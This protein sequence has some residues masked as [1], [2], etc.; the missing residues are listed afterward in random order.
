MGARENKLRPDDRACSKSVRVYNYSSYC[1]VGVFARILYLKCL[2]GIIFQL[3]YFLESHLRIN[4]IRLCDIWCRD[5]PLKSTTLYINM[6]P[7]LWPLLWLY[8]D[9]LGNKFETITFILGLLILEN[10][11]HFLPIL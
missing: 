5:S 7:A 8:S 2:I 9:F 6:N 3:V 10:L 4:D 11:N 1:R